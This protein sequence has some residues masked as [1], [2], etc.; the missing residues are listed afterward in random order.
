VQSIDRP[1]GAVE[2]SSSP[3]LLRIA[4]HSPPSGAGAA[5]K[6]PPIAEPGRR[7]APA[8]TGSDPPRAEDAK[9]PTQPF[10]MLPHAIASDT[11]LSPTERLICAAL[12]YWA[13]DSDRCACADWRI[14][15]YVGVERE[16]VSRALQR[17]EKAGHV[18]IEKFT[19]HAR[20]MTGREI[21][22]CWRQDPS[23]LPPP[24]DRRARCGRP[25]PGRAAAEGV[26]P[27]SH[28]VRR[29]RHTPCDAQVTPGV[30]PAPHKEEPL[31]VGDERN[32]PRSGEAAASQ[33][34]P[35][36]VP[37]PA[38]PPNPTER[39]DGSLISN[40]KRNDG[41]QLGPLKSLLDKLMDKGGKCADQARSYL[42]RAAAAG[43]GPRMISPKPID[44]GA[45]KAR[46]DTLMKRSNARPETIERLKALGLGCDPRLVDGCVALL[47]RELEGDGHSQGFFVL[48]LNEV[49]QGQIPAEA[50]VH[51]YVRA[52]GP[53]VR[54][55]GAAFVA[56]IKPYRS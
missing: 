46:T 8:R 18:R 43:D 54:N 53:R 29:P 9:P 15:D 47:C 38:P 55:R 1:G 25:R 2:D 30:A 16:T 37:A 26:T 51:A 42:P 52:C 13:L 32:N 44:P 56:A 14:A 17:I 4:G 21:V 34:A 24:P 11:R 50:I 5:R 22:L 36:P 20:N 40:D 6:R 27:R 12:L 3:V 48:I 19:P 41:V 28:P 33:V 49:R 31:A 35:A 7:P 23:Y 10:A 45:L 39:G